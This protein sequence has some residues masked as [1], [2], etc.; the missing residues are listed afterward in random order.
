MIPLRGQP[1]VDM[2]FGPVV[3]PF[4][5]TLKKVEKNESKHFK[6]WA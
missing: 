1:W 6:K 2:N 5:N 4:V 3:K